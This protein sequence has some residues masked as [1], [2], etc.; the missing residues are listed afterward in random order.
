MEVGGTDSN[1]SRAAVGVGVGQR[2]LELHIWIFGFPLPAAVVGS[3]VMAGCGQRAAGG[4]VDYRWA[5]PVAGEMMAA[6]RK[7]RIAWWGGGCSG[8]AARCCLPW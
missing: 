1:E 2:E 5:V 3:T 7:G 8:V 4:M 6:V